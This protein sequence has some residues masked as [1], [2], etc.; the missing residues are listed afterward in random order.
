MLNYILLIAGFAVLIKSASLLVDGGAAIAKHF[1]VSNIVIG[2]TIVAFGTSAPEFVVS[3][4]SSWRGSSDLALTNI[5][6]SVVTNVLLGLGLAAVIYSLK[7]SKGTVWKEIPL[8]LLAVVILLLLMNDHWIADG[9]IPQLSWIDGAVLLAF[10][11]IFM[12]YTFGISK[13]QSEDKVVEIKSQLSVKKSSIYIILGLIGLFIGGKWIVDNAVII[14]QQLGVTEKM[15]GLLIVGPGT[16]LPEIASTAMAA[17]KKQVDMAVGG[18]IGSNIFNIFFILGMS[19][20]VGPIYYD[21]VLN[22]DMVLI[23][24]ASLLLFF[25]LFIGKRHHIERWQGIGFI[26]LYLVYLGYL[27]FRG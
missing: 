25:T 7:V 14:A 6:G 13:I 21:T 23:L 1:S 16:S 4:L 26:L 5:V 9:G 2:L 11:V 19:S 15:I 22:V 3:F 10:F 27:L 17:R 24:F 12:Y 8:S 20:L 18:V